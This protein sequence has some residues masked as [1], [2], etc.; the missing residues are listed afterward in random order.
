MRA[1]VRLVSAGAV[2]GVLAAGMVAFAPGAPAVRAASGSP[3]P[4][5][6]RVPGSTEY[7][8]AGHQEPPIPTIVPLPGMQSRLAAPAGARS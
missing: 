5:Q 4:R 6:N 2:A 8:H 3:Q 7:P 1:V